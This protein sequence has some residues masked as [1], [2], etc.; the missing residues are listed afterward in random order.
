M[1]VPDMVDGAGEPGSL[2]TGKAW[3]GFGASI[4]ALCLTVVYI[5]LLQVRRGGPILLLPRVRDEGD[6]R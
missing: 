2:T 5:I 1:L 6:G 3:V 4:G